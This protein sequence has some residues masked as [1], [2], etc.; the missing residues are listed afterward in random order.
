MKIGIPDDYA[1]VVRTLAAFK[2]IAGHAVSIWTD[3]APDL[4]AQVERLKDIEALTLLRER[5][6]ISAALVARLPALRLITISGPYPNVDVA[7]CT[8]HGIAV[9]ASINR[10]STATPELTWGLVLAAM[11]NIP[12]EV[13]R[14]KGGAWQ[15]HIGRVLHGRTLGILGFGRIGK[16]V[17]GYGRAFGMRVL[18]WSRARGLAEA[19]AQGF[20]LAGGP[21]ELYAEADVLSVHLRLTPETRGFITRADLARMKPTSLF[22]NTSRAELVEPDALVAA[23]RAGRPGSAAVDVYEHEP[24]TGARHPLLDLPN[25]LCTPHLGFVALDQLDQYFADQ[26]DCVL[27]FARGEPIDVINPEVLGRNEVRK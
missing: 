11:R 10:A 5:T 3:A 16:A 23:L 26:F 4:D 12:Q 27:A 6:P 14:L 7:A 17:A 2:T 21:D 20:E 15:G 24:V 13:S 22:V 1:D 18:V 25:A 19:K 9:C 8:A